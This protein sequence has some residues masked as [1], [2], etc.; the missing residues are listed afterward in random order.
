MATFKINLRADNYE[1]NEGIK[2][3]VNDKVYAFEKFLPISEKEEV[4]V[5]VVLAK[6]TQHH[7]NGEIY[8][9]EFAL[10][11]KKEFKHSEII[12]ENMISSIEKACEEINRQILK[13]KEKKINLFRAGSEKAKK[14]LR[15]RS[16]GE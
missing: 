6:T 11:Y 2:N 1:L 13:T 9:A 8:R 5:D 14:W 15:F 10:K 7:N 16:K 4:I 12:S 3:F